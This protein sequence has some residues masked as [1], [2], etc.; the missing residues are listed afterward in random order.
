[1]KTLY[2]AKIITDADIESFSTLVYVQNIAKEACKHI[3]KIYPIYVLTRVNPKTGTISTETDEVLTLYTYLAR[4]LPHG[5]NCPVDINLSV[6]Q[7]D[8]PTYSAYVA[9]CGD[10]LRIFPHSCTDYN[11]KTAC[12][13]VVSKIRNACLKDYYSFDTSLPTDVSW[14]YFM[15][16]DMFLN[17]VDSYDADGMPII[18]RCDTWQNALIAFAIWQYLTDKSYPTQVAPNRPIGLS[19]FPGYDS[20]CHQSLYTAKTTSAVRFNTTRL[21]NCVLLNTRML[22]TMGLSY[23]TEYDCWDDL[24]MN[25]QVAAIARH[26]SIAIDYPI[27][28]STNRPMVSNTSNI[29]YSTN[30]LNNYAAQMYYK[31]GDLIKFRTWKNSDGLVYAINSK[32]PNDFT[33]LVLNKDWQPKFSPDIL[34]ALRALVADDSLL[35]SFVDKYVTE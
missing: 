9:E 35:D 24:D 21:T 1:M 12:P 7:F 20:V 8:T 29:V 16:D 14:M 22:R 27:C 13:N 34:T 23:E 2:D 18:K 17:R 30:K 25:L 5:A 19:G 28:S 10:A 32:L 4:A 3:T 15:E 26:N 33:P 6:Y 11:F 31:W